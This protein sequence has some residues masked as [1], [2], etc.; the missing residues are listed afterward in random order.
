MKDLYL[1][2]WLENTDVTT[3]PFIFST[4]AITVL[5]YI[6]VF[7]AVCIASFFLERFRALSD[8]DKF[9][10]CAKGT[11]LFY[12]P[13][14]IFT[15]LWYLLVDNTL[16]DDVINGTT[17]TTFIAIYIYT[18]WFQPLWQYSNSSGKAS[19]WQLNQYSVIH[20]SFF[21]S[22][23]IQCCYIYYNGKGQY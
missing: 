15:G 16:R 22:Q 23:S 14:P 20:S 8:V 1:L 18:C 4:I 2:P 6:L 5:V 10:W 13:F 7:V 17:K 21:H 12:F 3:W 9:I 19:L 11:K